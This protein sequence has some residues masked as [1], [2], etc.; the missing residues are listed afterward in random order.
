METMQ[1]STSRWTKCGTSISWNIVSNKKGWTINTSNNVC[2]S[3]NNHT[4]WKKSVKKST[5]KIPLIQNYRKYK[6]IHSDRKEIEEGWK[7]ALQGLTGGE[8]KFGGSQVCRLPWLWQ[9]FH[10]CTHMP[11]LYKVHAWNMCGL[12]YVH[13]NMLRQI[14]KPRENIWASGD[15]T[16]RSVPEELKIRCTSVPVWM[17]PAA[18]T[19]FPAPSPARAG[20][21]VSVGPRLGPWGM[22]GIR[23][24]GSGHQASHLCWVVMMCNHLR[25]IRLKGVSASNVISEGPSALLS[26]QM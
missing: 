4:E 16:H 18:R 17:I 24:L 15:S 3:Q 13:I 10:G 26:V 6:V 12:L 5:K 7:D 2:E 9:W 14:W 20:W 23:A 21:R 19:K 22:P 8:R 11:K 1:T 25:V